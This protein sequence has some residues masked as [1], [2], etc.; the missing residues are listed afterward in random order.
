M[1]TERRVGGKATIAWLTVRVV[2]VERHCVWSDVLYLLQLVCD[3][4]IYSWKG[5]SKVEDCEDC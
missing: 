1:A 4:T 3:E 5:N 2:V